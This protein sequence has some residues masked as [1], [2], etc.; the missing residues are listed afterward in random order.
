MSE[1]L[2]KIILTALVVLTVG[3]MTG[4]LWLLISDIVHG[5]KRRNL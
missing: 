3:G 1:I 5:Y 4:I 2:L